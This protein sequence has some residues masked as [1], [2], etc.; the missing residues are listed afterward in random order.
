MKRGATVF[1]LLAL[2]V[3]GCARPPTP[4]SP[5]TATIAVFPPNNRTGNDLLV[6]PGS[7]LGKYVF[8]TER[9]T[10]SDVLAAEARLQL[11]RRGYMLVPAETVDTA[12]GGVR[13]DS[14]PAAAMLASR[15]HIDASVLY[16]EIRNWEPNG[17]FTPDFV[18]VSI[19]ATLIDPPTGR[20]L[21]TADHPSRPVPTPGVVVLGE[22]YVIAAAK[23]IAEMFAGLGPTQEPAHPELRPATGARGAHPHGVRWEADHLAVKSHVHRCQ[24]SCPATM[25]FAFAGKQLQMHPDLSMGNPTADSWRQQLRGF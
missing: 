2:T 7:L 5:P 19:V 10:V 3:A 16:I 8:N 13:P 25:K 17:P 22:A 14:A 18:I 23:V 4:V 12:L 20:V 11:A 15:Q 21:W 9:V 1:I 24:E 6:A